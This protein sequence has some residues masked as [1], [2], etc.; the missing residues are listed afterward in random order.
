MKK[1]LLSLLCVLALAATAQA[2]SWPAWGQE[3][4]AWG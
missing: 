4:L 1:F 3:A 2:A